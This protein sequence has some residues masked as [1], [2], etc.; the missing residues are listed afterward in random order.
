MLFRRKFGVTS[1]EREIIYIK[2]YVESN[3]YL[4]LVQHRTIKGYEGH[5]G[6]AVLRSIMG[7]ASARFKE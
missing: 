4:D 3:M 5:R 7:G 1:A 6:I 2:L